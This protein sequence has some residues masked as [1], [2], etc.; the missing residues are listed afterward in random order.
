MC[1]YIYIYTYVCTC[2]HTIVYYGIC[3]GRHPGNGQTWPG[4]GFDDSNGQVQGVVKLV[5]QGR[6]S[7]VADTM[8]TTSAA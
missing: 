7:S 1:V 3:I 5:E 8:T 2:G 6:L 4:Y